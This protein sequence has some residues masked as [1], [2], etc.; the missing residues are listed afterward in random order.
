[1][2]LTGHDGPADAS[3]LPDPRRFRYSVAVPNPSISLTFLGAAGTVTGS[4]HLLEVD[5][6]RLL[7]D[8]GL[9]QGL[10][11]LRQRNWEPL[12]VD[13]STIEAVILTHAHLDHCGYLPRLVAAGF[14]GRIFCTPGTKDLCSLVLPDAAHIQEEDA[15]EANRGGFT[16]HSPALP[17]YTS[18]DAARTL[19]QLQPVGYDRE[20]PLWGQTG[21]R[22]GV[23]PPSDPIGTV[24]FINAG[25]LLGSAY[26]RVRVAGKTILFGGD[27]G[28]YGRPVLPDP[29]PVSDADVL[30]LESTY[31]DRLH[32]PDDNGARLAAIVN[33]AA[34]R[35]GKLIIPS[36]AIGRVE[37][38]LYWLKRLE[39]EKRIPVLP[40]YLD[41][42]MAIGALQ[43]YASR[44]NELDAELQ[45][46]SA[47]F[48]SDT[49]LRHQ[50]PTLN[51]DTNIRHRGLR[52]VSAFATTRLTTVASPQQSADLVASRQP[53]IV[54]ASSGMATGGRVL[55]HLAAT[56][57]N[58]KTTVMFVGYQAAGTRGRLLV[59]GAREI[60]LLGRVYP[61][62]AQVERIDSMSAHA[63]YSES[64]RWLSGF[65]SAPAMT[66]L[67]HGDPIALAALAAR[68]TTEKQWPVHI[69][70]HHER[71]EVG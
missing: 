42:P 48:G 56:I 14:R 1:M 63:D 36:F 40:V 70:A 44:L 58:P 3:R 32:E 33:D 51:S 47:T 61:V 27:L 68:I 22:M 8:C 66:Y 12:P 62:A 13:P 35:G 16:K 41:S 24:E 23:G 17:L 49:K 7:V 11:D 52:D 28:R 15:R 54:I 39:E 9:F 31:G 69:A 19:S 37:E 2:S 20:I 29:A 30:L 59:D 25:H 43:F 67:V 60:K 50:A 38:V 65:T 26:A 64:M 34:A 57:T 18:N 45:P 55:R 53:S 46:Q 21:V 4:K 71:V 10:K 6:R 5:G